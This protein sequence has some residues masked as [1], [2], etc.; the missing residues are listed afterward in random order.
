[1]AG[2]PVYAP[3][4]GLHD[5]IVQAV[6]A[7]DETIHGILAAPDTSP[8]AAVASRPRAWRSC[9]S[10]RRL[11]RAALERAHLNVSQ[12]A[13]LGQTLV[14]VIL[15]ERAETWLNARRSETCRR[16]LAAIASRLLQAAELPAATAADPLPPL[17]WLL[18]AR[19]VGDTGSSS[20]ATLVV[21]EVA[22]IV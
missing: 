21:P 2:I 12:A 19:R 1:M 9:P 7:F 8:R 16:I 6:G 18:G 22:S 10:P 5:F 17:R 20:F 3:E 13:L 11:H 15:T 4:P 14:Q